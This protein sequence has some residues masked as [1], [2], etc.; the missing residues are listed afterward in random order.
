VGVGGQAPNDLIGQM[1][2]EEEFGD[3]LPHSDPT[4]SEEVYGSDTLP[5]VMTRSYQPGGYRHNIAVPLAVREDLIDK[6]T[7]CPNQYFVD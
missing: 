6:G 3:L 4:L 7:G 2:M 1:L 5:G